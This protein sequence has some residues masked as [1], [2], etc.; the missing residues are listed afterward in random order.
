LSVVPIPVGSRHRNCS[1]CCRRTLAA[2]LVSEIVG[3]T[4]LA[5]FTPR[6]ETVIDPE[7]CA[8]VAAS[9]A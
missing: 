3:G 4:T 7:V 5:A 1:G 6:T 9:L 2:P 8:L